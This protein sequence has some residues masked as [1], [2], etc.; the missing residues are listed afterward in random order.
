LESNYSTY[1]DGELLVLLQG[2][3]QSAFAELYQRYKLDVYRYGLTI[4]KIPQQAE[5]L[6]QDTFISLWDVRRRLEIKTGLRQYLLRICHNKAIDI[7]KKVAANR[8]LVDQLFT[9]YQHET[10]SLEHSLPDLQRYDALVEEALNSLSPQRRK[11]YELCKKEKKTYEEV[12]R[13]LNLSVNTVKAHMTQA[14]ALLREYIS[15]H[16]KIPILILLLQKFL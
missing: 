1:S 4:V 10:T 15:K 8:Q 5:D 11:V 2:D 9:Y 7:N 14:A 3:D 13:E 12:A 6:L 16:G